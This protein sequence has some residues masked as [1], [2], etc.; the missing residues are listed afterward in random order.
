MQVNNEILQTL[1]QTAEKTIRR[2]AEHLIAQRDKIRKVVATEDGGKEVKLA[3]DHAMNEIILGDLKETGIAILSEESGTI[4]GSSHPELE[5]VVDPLD[6]SVNFLR[7]IDYCAIS[8]ALCENEKP[9][10]GLI[11]DLTHDCLA[12]GIVGQ[13]ASIEGEP[14]QVAN[15]SDIGKAILATGF[16][17]RMSYESDALHSFVSNVQRF[18][19]IRMLGS[20]AQMLLQVAIGSVDAYYEDNIMRW[21][22]A[23]GLALIEAAGGKWEWKQGSKPESRIVR[24]SCPGIWEAFQQ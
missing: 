13:G 4:E 21:D 1:T 9:I 10:I 22:V 11:Y 7:G 5:W 6:G 12:M 23:G 19:K 20:A 17:A 15:T 2:A 8:I 24:A 18:Q 3:A 16:P 14:I